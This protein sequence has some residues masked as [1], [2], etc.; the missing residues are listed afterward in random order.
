MQGYQGGDLLGVVDKLDYLQDLGITALYLN[1][2][3]ASAANHR[4]HTYDYMRVDPLLGGDAALRKLL[5]EAHRRGIHIVLDGVFNH[6]S[7]GFW[8]FHHILE[9]GG[10]SPYVDWFTVHDWPLRPYE[11]DAQN[12]HNYAAWWDM[13]A[14]PKFN[15]A[16]PGVR[17]YLLEVARYWIEFGADGWRLDVPEE[18]DD[19]WFWHD[20][21]CAVKAVDPDA[22]LVGEIWHEA[23]DWLQGDRFDA[24][25]NYVYARAALGFFARN[26]LRT[27]YKPGGYQL[28]RLNAEAFGR[29]IE[30]AHTAYEWQVVQAQLNLIDSHDT[31][32]TLWMVDG[33]KSA[34]ELCVLFQMTMPGAPC[35][36]YGD[37]IGMTGG[38][39]PGCRGP[40]PW[41]EA[42][43]WDHALLD[44][45][46]RA[47]ALRHRWRA[48]RT[49]TF[50]ALY[51]K[52]NVYAFR[53]RLAD[54]DLI[55]IF[56]V[57]SRPTRVDLSL[58]N[59]SVGNGSYEG[60]WNSGSYPALDDRLTG[61]RV[62]ARDALVLSRGG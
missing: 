46:R 47:I 31:A 51:A 38:H 34:L 24:V 4:Y 18:I 23:S 45:F 21:R 22:Y 2:I 42:E 9:N 35:V 33:D 14:L 7:R 60:I 54:E 56:N 39:E 61:V 50:E 30:D 36:Y 26:T 20:F 28:E 13:P 41:D 52:D 27:D 11:H 17:D 57:D 6:A 19:G 5:D 10:D 55:V 37:E 59:D 32:R 29:A 8:A 44:F 62:P 48:L 3:F 58:G 15:I 12:S 25:M 49:G 43:R 16:N 40:F 53:R 1:P